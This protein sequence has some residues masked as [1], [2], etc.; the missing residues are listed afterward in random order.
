MFRK[1]ERKINDTFFIYGLSKDL[2]IFPNTLP[3]GAGKLIEAQDSK[4]VRQQ[5]RWF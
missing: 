1:K 3:R 4:A 5:K 2:K